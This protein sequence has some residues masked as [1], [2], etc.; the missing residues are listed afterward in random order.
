MAD[1]IQVISNH[2]FDGKSP[3]F[4]KFPEIIEAVKVEISRYPK[5]Y[6]IV[7]GRFLTPVFLNFAKWDSGYF[8][9]P[10]FHKLENYQN[11]LLAPYG[12]NYDSLKLF[13]RNG[14]GV[15]VW[16]KGSGIS[17]Y[18]P[19]DTDSI[20][21]S[22]SLEITN[23]AIPVSDFAYGVYDV[24]SNTIRDGINITASKIS[25][26]RYRFDFIEAAVKDYVVTI[27]WKTDNPIND[28]STYD[29]SL[30]GFSVRFYDNTFGNDTDPKEITINV[31]N[32][33]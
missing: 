19:V 23:V 26:G 16:I 28:S 9:Q 33:R 18:V 6:A 2:T 14:I 30:T 3:L 17:H 27:N 20:T 29:E 5:P 10:E 8:V 12:A 32:R 21:A 25:T 15:N 13:A 4:F 11:F 22:V 24:E 1:F 31:R 7:W